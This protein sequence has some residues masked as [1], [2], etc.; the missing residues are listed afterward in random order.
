[1]RYFRNYI[2]SF[3][4]EPEDSLINAINKGL[5]NGDVRFYDLISAEFFTLLDSKLFEKIKENYK[6]FEEKNLNSY[7][8]DEDNLPF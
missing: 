4:K 6:N 5:K 7:T 8:Y 3:E 2:F 1:M